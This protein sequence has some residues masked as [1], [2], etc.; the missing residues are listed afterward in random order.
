M[1]EKLS[2]PHI[3]LI[4]P[5]LNNSSEIP[6]FIASIR[7]QRYP[8]K[9]IE[10]IFVDGGSQDDTIK[11]AKRNKVKVYP[12]PYKL[13]EPGVHIGM[14]KATGD[15]IMVLATDNIYQDT[16]ALLKMARVFQ[17]K[18]VF[19]ALP[20]QNYSPQD[21]L[22]TKYHN[23]FTDP[24]NHFVQGD[25]SNTRTFH[26]VYK[27]LFHNDLYDIYDFK[28][29]PLVPMMSF[30]QGFTVR[31]TFR[32]K[33]EDM[34][35]DNSPVIDIIEKRKKIAYVHSLSIYHS[36]IRNL[37]HFMKK[38][39]W[40]TE[41]VLEKKNYGIGHRFTKLS[42]VQKMKIYIWPIYSLSIIFPLIRSV[43]GVI[44]DRELIWLFD[45]V[46]SFLCACAN[47]IQLLEYSKNRLL[48]R[49]TKNFRQ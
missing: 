28:N 42:S 24:F 20:K 25:A 21:N 48:R 43:V 39:R 49:S 14:T 19:A 22:F 35:D 47:L 5:T 13:A 3:S 30:S 33:K 6:R 11:K 44:Q 2:L 46:D 29:S 4:V 32:R 17:D 7:N 16:S 18:T 34:Y 8:Q 40:A 38:Q 9:K 41:N 31:G 26:K 37:S 12:N 15:I 36:T 10:I 23:T 27:T 45:P 1:G